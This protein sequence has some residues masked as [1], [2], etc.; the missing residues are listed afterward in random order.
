MVHRV[1]R[2]FKQE[3][4]DNIDRANKKLGWK[5]RITIS[6]IFRNKAGRTSW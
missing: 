2:S 5:H 1:G 6:R 3:M 4:F